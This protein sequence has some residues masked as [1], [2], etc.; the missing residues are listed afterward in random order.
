MIAEL[1][2]DFRD[3]VTLLCKYRIKFVIVGGYA[4]NYYGYLR[5]TG[6]IDFAIISGTEDINKLN[7][8]LPE[9]A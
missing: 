9:R 7:D 1:N 5:A 4:V 2:E 8:V 3:F 6:D